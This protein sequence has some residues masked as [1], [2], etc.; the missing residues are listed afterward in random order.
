MIFRRFVHGD[1][2]CASY[3]LGCERARTAVVVDP[4]ADVAPYLAA[5]AQEGLRLTHVIETHLQADHL[6]GAWRLRQAT[7]APVLAHPGAG[8]RF[9]HVGVDDHEEH[10]V[11]CA[12]LT[13]RYTPGHTPDGLSVLVADRRAGLSPRLALTGDTLLAGSVGSPEPSDG[14]EAIRLAEQLHASLHQILLRLPDDVEV[15]PAHVAVASPSRATTI[16]A[17]RRSN[18]ALQLLCRDDFVQYVVQ[19]L[20]APPTPP[21]APAGGAAE[22]RRRNQTGA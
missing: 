10:E 22:F 1:G 11:G 19:R 17:E 9:P 8:L 7:G 2:G 16:G 12:R 15:H 21:R 14:V 3:L 4:Q 5:A 6:S 18:P 13:F 20:S